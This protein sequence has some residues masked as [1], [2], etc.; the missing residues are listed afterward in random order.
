[1][2]LVLLLVLLQVVVLLLVVRW[3]K[4][5]QKWEPVTYSPLYSNN[6]TRMDLKARAFAV[7]VA[8]SFRQSP[9]RPDGPVRRYPWLR[10]TNTNCSYTA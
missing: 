9:A 8:V 1:M 3:N 10:S 7:S 4:G 2:L 5:K 6:K